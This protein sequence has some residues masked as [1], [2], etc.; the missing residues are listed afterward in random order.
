MKYKNLVAEFFKTI[1]AVISYI[2]YAKSILN[3]NT[4]V[5]Y[6]ASFIYIMPQLIDTVTE[7][8]SEYLTK[9]MRIIDIVAMV[10]GAIVT[11]VV[12][13]YV[14]MDGN[15]NALLSWMLV[16]LSAC[17]VTRS[18]FKTGKEFHRHLNVHKSLD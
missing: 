17:F 6:L 16:I 18:I 15:N 1:F 12:M 2:I 4:T 8:S 13:T 10:I 11:V 7:F 5:T 3:G 14:S 9:T